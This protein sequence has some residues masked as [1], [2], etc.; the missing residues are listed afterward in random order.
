MVDMM[1]N[2]SDDK[3]TGKTRDTETVMRGLEGGCWKS[4]LTK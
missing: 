2:L 4:A 1:E 3:I